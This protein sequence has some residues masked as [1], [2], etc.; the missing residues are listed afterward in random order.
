[1]QRA[2][3][4]KLETFDES[5]LCWWLEQR[6]ARGSRDPRAGD[7]KR[8]LCRS[9]CEQRG[10]QGAKRANNAAIG[11]NAKMPYTDAA[12]DEKAEKEKTELPALDEVVL[13]GLSPFFSS[14]GK[15]EQ[16][17]LGSAGAAQAAA[18]SREGGAKYGG[19]FWRGKVF[20]GVAGVQ[21]GKKRRGKQQE[22]EMARRGKRNCRL[23]KRNVN[24]CVVCL[25][26]GVSFSG[27]TRDEAK[28]NTDQQRRDDETTAQRMSPRQPQQAERRTVSR[29][30]EQ[31]YLDLI[32]RR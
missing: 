30:N 3:D 8:E 23:R 14:V 6:V 11:L 16:L 24:A 7:S 22:M 18:P 31:T 15:P 9:N 5:L 2:V 20:G 10:R 17:R 32:E 13:T 27:S 29:R 4:A 12:N 1:M 26:C 19:H 28:T 25:A 21:Q